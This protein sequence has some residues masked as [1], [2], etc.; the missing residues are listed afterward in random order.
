M[1]FPEKEMM[2]AKY[3]YSLDTDVPYYFMFVRDQFT[4][5]DWPSRDRKGLGNKVEVPDYPEYVAYKTEGKYSISNSGRYNILTVNE[6][7]FL[8]LSKD[9]DICVL[10]E[11]PNDSNYQPRIYW[12]VNQKILNEVS[13]RSVGLYTPEWNNQVKYSTCKLEF[14]GSVIA[15]GPPF[16]LYRY[17]GLWLSGS[18]GNDKSQ[19]ID[20][21]ANSG[22]NKLVIINGL[23]LPDCLSAY[24][25]VGRV[26]KIQVSYSGIEQEFVL[27]DTPNPQLVIL[28][29]VLPRG[30]TIHITVIDVYKGTGSTT[31]ALSFVG[32]LSLNV[33][34]N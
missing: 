31:V 9:D 34:I 16:N 4:L 19:W 1:V 20:I 15:L 18:E 27:K 25:Y 33:D 6:R 11:R 10:I 7:S 17:R 26:K 2:D 14:P 23:V 3:Y 13:K 8:L 30:S 5:Y 29:D 32:L 12:G 28:K 22:S 21:V 24:G